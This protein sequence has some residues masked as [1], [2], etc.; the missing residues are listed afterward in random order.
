MVNRTGTESNSGEGSKMISEDITLDIRSKTFAK[1][2]YAIL[3]R[4]V[5]GDE[6]VIGADRYP[7][8][9]VDNNDPLTN[10]RCKIR[11]NQI[12]H[13][14][15]LDSELPWA[16]PNFGFFGSKVGSFT[17]PPIGAGVFVSF[18]HNDIYLPIYDSSSISSNNLP[19]DAKKNYP[20]NVVLWAMDNGSK[21]LIN[22]ATE[23]ITI[24]QANGGTITIKPSGN[25]VIDGCKVVDVSGSSHTAVGGNFPLLYAVGGVPGSVITDVS[26]IGVCSNT[27]GG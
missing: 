9:V 6:S 17:V 7:G 4:Y 26:Q 20:D 21:C 10:G 11:V 15:I 27:T 25:I 16:L 1:N 5:N 18:D 2:I 22:R 19:S 13:S 12:Y 3:D 23:E 14:G 24:K 8:I